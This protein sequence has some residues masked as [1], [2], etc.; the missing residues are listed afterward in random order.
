MKESGA[1]EQRSMGKAEHQKAALDRAAQ[2]IGEHCDDYLILA[3]TGRRGLSWRSSDCTWAVGAAQRYAFSLEE[4]DRIDE[5]E[6]H[7]G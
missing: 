5:A 6:S 1:E 7:K 2:L 3:R 4:S